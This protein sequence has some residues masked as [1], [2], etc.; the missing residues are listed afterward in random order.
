MN[1]KFHNLLVGVSVLPA[2]LVMPAMAVNVANVADFNTALTNGGNINLA[3]D[4]SFNT[5]YNTVN[6]NTVIDGG[7]HNIS[8][9]NTPVAL[10]EKSSSYT[11]YR[12]T[13]DGTDTVF[14]YSS[15]NVGS[16]IYSDYER[17]E[18]IG[19]VYMKF[20]TN[21]EPKCSIDAEG[22]TKTLTY[23][24]EN[25]SGK[26]V[27]FR[28]ENNNLVYAYV[29]QAN[30]TPED[31]TTT[32]KFYSTKSSSSSYQ[33]ALD[34][35]VSDGEG[36]YT[37]KEHE[38]FTYTIN[39]KPHDTYI[40]DGKEYYAAYD[41]TPTD[42]KASPT[43][44]TNSK[45]YTISNGQVTAF[46]DNLSVSPNTDLTVRN[47]NV[48]GFNS[49][50][51]GA[52]I[53]ADNSSSTT[54]N[55][56]VLDNVHFEGNSGAYSL[57]YGENV[58]LVATNIE[59]ENNQ[60]SVFYILASEANIDGTFTGNTASR[61][62]VVSLSGGGNVTVSGSF[63]QNVS[64]FS[65]GSGGGAIAGDQNTLTIADGT[66]FTN[67]LAKTAGGG[68][69]TS[70]GLSPA[71]N[72]GKDGNL[73]I[74]NN[75]IFRE[76]KAG[77]ANLDG[78]G[79]TSTKGNGGAVYISA[80][81]STPTFGTGVKFIDNKAF[82]TGGALALAGTVYDGN[83]FVI[84]NGVEFTGNTAQQG[85]ALSSSV[86]VSAVLDNLLFNNNHANG[87]DV[88]IGGALLVSGSI[89]N[90]STPENA[91]SKV[92][93]L[94]ITNTSFEDNL[95]DTAGGAIGQMGIT[96][97]A[98]NKYSQGMTIDILNSTFTDN[99]AGA[100]G[101]AIISDAI[102]NVTGSAFEGNQTTG[103]VIGVNSTDSNEGGG[104]I[105]MYDDSVATITNS[106]FTS[107]ESGTWGGA[108]S[109]RGIS[110]AQPGA[111]S[112]LAVNGGTFTTNNAVYGGAIANSLS[113]TVDEGNVVTKYGARINGVTFTGNT[114]TTNG[115]AI[116]NVGDITLAGTNTF[117]G[118]TANGLANDIHNVGS[119]TVA[120]GTTTMDGGITG[121]GTLSIAN[122][123][124]LNIGTASINQGTIDLA[125]TLIATVRSGDAQ[126]TATDAFAGDGTLSLIFNDAGTYH[127]FGD[128]VLASAKNRVSSTI[129]DLSWTNED[130]DVTAT[131]KSVE[132]IAEENNL[133]ENSA[134]AILGM[135]QS[136]S[137]KL[138]E[139][140][141]KMQ[142]KLA[143]ATP[144][145]Q[146]EVEHAA[147]A[148]HP[149]N[150]SVK[151]SVAT[152]VQTTVANLA[153]ARMA[154]PTIGRSGGD[155]NFTS[156]GV[157]AQ[158]LFNK[159]KQDDAFSGY[160]RGI[161]AGMDGTINKVW[162]VGAGYSF[163]HSDITSVR[164]TE[165]DSNTV[166]LYGQY[167]PAEWYV[168]AVANYTWS[169]F[170]ETADVLG[171]AKT[172]DY[173]VNAFGGTVATG[174]NFASGVTPELG[175]RY[176]HVNASDYTDS[177]GSKIKSKDTDFLT[178]V[179]GAKYAFNVVADKYTT[180]IPQ[181][182]AAIKYDMLSDKNVAT[183][184]MP[185]V[186]SYTLRGE[187]LNRLGGEFGIGLGMKYR[188][189]DF[190]I[191]YDIDVRKDYT[192]QTGMLKFR[193]NF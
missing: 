133:S 119:L 41:T 14:Y 19:T 16:A 10:P 192:S 103:T 155:V 36:H 122:G 118:N 32:T 97:F 181:L 142:E 80:V 27:A 5:P 125:G 182:N 167:K 68:A 46:T 26:Y 66:T 191:N 190:S 100:E 58:N 120:S 157:W 161:A 65:G 165:I 38:L 90:Q 48:S 13:M 128:K 153:G 150:E 175:L 145:A 29:N 59:A 117:T 177:F 130:K 163:A 1:K 168:N 172:A 121:D 54:K 189:M 115:G 44:E 12:A 67:N 52:F 93:T 11:V 21:A 75:V 37:I 92:K 173:D 7:N 15:I 176:L 105:F 28:D 170:S 47:V 64:S 39:A 6:S 69:L 116:Y 159:S 87:G 187:R 148:V 140:A 144:I 108:I 124:T 78:T 101:G 86:N 135:S 149:E 137:E 53:Y 62:A 57:V 186:D 147:K 73:H 114:A 60:K 112:S 4:I 34:G 123:A 55:N 95:S 84:N 141:E 51:N 35:F 139:V 40:I 88:A 193:Y 129:Y 183:V 20:G 30:P 9:L 3:G 185:G 171:T 63:E 77:F 127:V 136:S 178:G 132:A 110:S 94:T 104:A 134:A 179:L 164:D 89:T 8:V 102:L 81:G 24:A 43:L 45:A 2:L 151:Q 154:A 56:I 70:G 83:G 174:Y 85:G 109:T 49:A 143:E 113:N 106:T 160:T 50:V 166:F 111:K 17:T 42:L 158:G 82:N 99:T 184:T 188:A 18:E 91:A 76:N 152:S 131:L 96:A 169:D 146:Q 72:P 79:A 156:G 71:S 25:S 162:K 22:T 33:V 31:I 180:F 138:N 98:N 74:G 107:N 61:G 126:L 23:S